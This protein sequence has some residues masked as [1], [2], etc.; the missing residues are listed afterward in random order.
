M[1]RGQPFTLFD[2]LLDPVPAVPFGKML[3]KIA[4]TAR[5]LLISRDSEQVIDAAAA[6]MWMQDEYL[7]K[8]AIDSIRKIG[9]SHGLE[10]ENFT[11]DA[12]DINDV[13][14]WL[15]DGADK[16]SRS[17][18][19]RE[20]S[21]LAEL[22]PTPENTDPLEALQQ[23]IELFELDDELFPD[24]HEWE[25]FAVLSLMLLSEAIDQINKPAQSAMSLG[26]MT[27]P[28]VEFAGKAGELAI[29]AMESVCYAAEARNM[30]RVENTAA[31]VV[32][33]AVERAVKNKIS[34]NAAKA[35]HTRHSKPDGAKA[36]KQKIQAIWA[37]G[38]YSSRDTCAEEEYSAVGYRTLTTA[39]KALRGTPDP[40]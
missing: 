15:L 39:R 31:A 33:A 21:R 22:I 36:L 40:S 16:P 10:L 24:A 19:S 9:Q 17:D 27:P 28:A 11:P 3:P 30:A 25:Y 38:K 26:L 37:T 4:N 18:E 14:G 6:I 1:L 29:L 13:I 7:E 32:T 35:A 2:P 12:A 5:S 34:L 8:A 20:I 23:G